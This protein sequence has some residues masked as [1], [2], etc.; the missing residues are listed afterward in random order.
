MQTNLNC[1]NLQV[2]SYEAL[3]TARIYENPHVAIILNIP[4]DLLACPQANRNLELLIMQNGS[5]A[6]IFIVNTPKMRTGRLNCRDSKS[7]DW[8]QC[9]WGFIPLTQRP[10][11][12]HADSGQLKKKN[13]A[14]I[15]TARLPQDLKALYNRIIIYKSKDHT[16]NMIQHTIK[17]TSDANR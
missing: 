17:H 10:N 8:G 7:R 4:I 5:E 1:L 14:T 12:L 11:G 3:D 13:R 16:R 2:I 6:T 15:N 9:A